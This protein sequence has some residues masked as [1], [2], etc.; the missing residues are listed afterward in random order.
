MNSHIVAI[1]GD[2]SEVLSGF[3]PAAYVASASKSEDKDQSSDFILA[4]SDDKFFV[5]LWENA[6]SDTVIMPGIRFNASMYY[7][8]GLMY[9]R[10]KR[11]K[12]V[13]TLEEFS[14]PEIDKFIEQNKLHEQL[15]IGLLDLQ[16]Y[17]FSVVQYGFNA[18]GKIARMATKNTRAPWCRFARKNTTG[19]IPKVFLNADFGTTDYDKTKNIEIQNLPE[20]GQLEAAQALFKKKK[21]EFTQVVQMPDLHSSYYPVPDWYTSVKSGW[22][23]VGKLIAMSKKFMFKN[24]FAIKYHIEFHPDYWEARFGTVAWKKKNP[25]EQAAAKKDELDNIVKYLSGTEKTGSALYSEKTRNAVSRE[26]ESLI[27]INELKNN[28]MQDGQYMKEANEA[29]DHKLSSMMIHPEIIG[30]APGSKMGAGSGSANRVAFNQRVALSLF[31]QQL[32]LDTL[33]VVRDVNGWG[34]DVR[35]MFRQSL[36]TTLDT[37][38]EATKP[39]TPISNG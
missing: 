18:G 1:T 33:R 16:T 26:L 2:G 28:F 31:T 37:G 22:F 27:T 25:D 4:G 23:D 38:A 24:Q 14:N 5:N 19:D 8:G 3:K 10:L 12:G 39:S 29:S 7:G 11:E 17:G 34:D 35:F 13:T 20:F 6:E 21:M 32:I 15:Y 30:N 9:G 36:I